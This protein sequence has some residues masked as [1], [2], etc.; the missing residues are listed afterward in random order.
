[1]SDLP[2]EIK[3]AVDEELEAQEN[4]VEEVQPPTLPEPFF[5]LCGPLVEDENSKLQEFLGACL[6]I[7]SEEIK[8]VRIYVNTP[9]GCSDTTHGL[10]DLID[11]LSDLGINVEITG[12]G[13]VMSAGVLL[14]SGGTKGYRRA[15]KRTRWMI[16][17]V[18]GYI[19]PGSVHTH[20]VSALEMERHMD[21]Y[22]NRLVEN[23][24]VED[25]VKLRTFLQEIISRNTEHYFSSE[26]ALEMGLIDEIL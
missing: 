21:D 24:T 19:P 3:E 14:V 18:Q 5:S 20:R 6:E 2:K 22:V 25:K 15:T 7:E 11:S 4:Q 23:S 1:M 8:S 12:V 10:C 9:G 16:H 17:P 13:Q 26:E